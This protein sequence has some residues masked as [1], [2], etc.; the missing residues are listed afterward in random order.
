M[1]ELRL[2]YTS[3]FASQHTHRTGDRSCDF[4]YE[5]LSGYEWLTLTAPA[6]ADMPPGRR[7]GQRGGEEK[8]GT[9]G[10]GRGG[11]GSW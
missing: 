6:I 5:W 10:S 1:S 3:R 9:R 2:S 11:G 4:G 7:E 8:K